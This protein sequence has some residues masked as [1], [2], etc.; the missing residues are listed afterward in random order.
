MNASLQSHY[1]NFSLKYAELAKTVLDTDSAEYKFGWLYSYQLPPDFLRMLQKEGSPTNY[2]IEGNKVFCN[3]EDFHILYQYQV[4]ESLLPDY[5]VRAFEYEFA[6]VLSVA[7][8][9]DA[10]LA[11]VWASMAADAWLKARTIDSQNTPPYTIDG[12]AFALTA[13]R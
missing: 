5:F 2:S 9:R 7:L 11:D 4:D 8:L 10:D 13:V 6:K 3:D 12:S 1:W